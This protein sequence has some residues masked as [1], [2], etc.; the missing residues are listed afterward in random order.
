MGDDLLLSFYL[1]FNPLAFAGS[2][3]DFFGGAW[4]R[5]GGGGGGGGGWGGARVRAVQSTQHS[6]LPLPASRFPLPAPGPAPPGAA[7]GRG[8]GGW[9]GVVGAPFTF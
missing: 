9:V 3:Q 8:G 2:W 5:E 6:E 1:I 7:V 4:W